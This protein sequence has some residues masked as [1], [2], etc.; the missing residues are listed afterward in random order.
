VVHS[1]EPGVGVV[2]VAGSP[3]S[4]EAL[5]GAKPPPAPSAV[6]GKAIAATNP[7]TTAKRT[8]HPIPLGNDCKP[9]SFVGLRG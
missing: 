5:A 6:A 3:L 7:V 2:A 1:S 4:V 9:I 8:I